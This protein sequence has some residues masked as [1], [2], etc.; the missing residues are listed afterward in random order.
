MLNKYILDAK[1]FNVNVLP[2]N[3]NKSLINFI[4][5]DN[6]V[7][8]GLSG[9]K[10]IGETFAKEIIDNRYDGY[11][12]MNDFIDKVNPS[13]QQV[14]ALIKS[15]AIPCKDKRKTLIKY[16]KSTYEPLAF[17]PVEKLPTYQKLEDE[18]GINKERYRN[19]DKKYD[20]DKEK[21]LVDYNDKRKELFDKNQQ[22]RFE[23][24]IEANKKYLEDELFWEFESLQIFIND[25]PFDKA[26]NYIT[27]FEDVENGD[28]CT[29]VGVISKVQ[30]KKDKNKKQFAFINIYSTFGLV[31]GIVW[32]TQLKEYEDLIKNGQQLALLV[33]KDSE[34]KV[35]VEKVK[36][37]N[38]WLEHMRKKGVMV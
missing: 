26:Y 33:K 10:K 5:D 23:K 8:F 31:E 28:K 3:I 7:L 11:K 35:I 13:K 2:P 14:V 12:S 4:V 6:A 32:H 20:F 27:P 9:I 22:E 30:K 19:G 24:H 37:Y 18:W 21:M 29:I 38:I 16:L 36:P 25:N 15:G 17:K 34:D 1:V